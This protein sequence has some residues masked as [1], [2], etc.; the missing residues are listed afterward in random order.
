MTAQNGSLTGGARGDGS[1]LEMK[2][3]AALHASQTPG[4][5]DDHGDVAGNELVGI[6][7]GGILDGLSGHVAVLGHGLIDAQGVNGILAAQIRV[8][9]AV[10]PQHGPH[11]EGGVGGL[12]G[13]NAE[14][15]NAD[16]LKLGAGIQH[17]VPG[18]GHRVHAGLGQQ[19]HVA[20]HGQVIGGEGQAV[21]FVVPL[22]VVQHALVVL[23]HFDLGS[24]LVGQ[25][26]QN[27][28]LGVV[29]GIG[30]IYVHYVRQRA[31]GGHNAD[32]VSGLGQG[33]EL[34]FHVDAGFGGKI[35]DALIHNLFVGGIGNQERD[36]LSTVCVFR[37]FHFGY[38]GVCLGGGF[39]GCLT[40]AG[41]AHSHHSQCQ[42]QC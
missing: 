29:G 22:A 3:H 36:G 37:F 17:L 15:G 38:R 42:E 16:G 32:L 21:V 11:L 8:I 40:T 31:A 12:I 39:G 41:H 10:A 23:I 6:V 7:A 30:V 35:A 33:Q 34:D 5:V 19:I 9:H 18:G 2:V 28:H 27:A 4:A 26:C 13:G 14:A 20:V 24:N 25:V 1:D